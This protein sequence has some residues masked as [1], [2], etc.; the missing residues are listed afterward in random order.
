MKEVLKF[1]DVSSID[2][3]PSGFVVEECGAHYPDLEGYCIYCSQ[4]N[5]NQLKE[6]VLNNANVN[7]DHFQNTFDSKPRQAMS[8]IAM[9]GGFKSYTEELIYECGGLQQFLDRY[10]KSSVSSSPLEDADS[11]EDDFEEWGDSEQNDSEENSGEDAEQVSERDASLESAVPEQDAMIKAAAE[12]R[13][14]AERLLEDAKQRQEEV[15]KKEAET[16]S[17]MERFKDIIDRNGNL[18]AFSNPDTV[19]ETLD[20]LHTLNEKIHMDGMSQGELLSAEYVPQV[21]ELLESLS[22][23]LY[24]RFFTEYVKGITEDASDSVIIRRSAMVNDLADY[25]MRTTAGGL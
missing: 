15:Q 16:A 1:L 3:V 23:R 6:W 13:A 17:K 20:R 18:I 2:S 10:C 5:A 12:L 19:L 11:G 8:F 22:P 14:E 24:K 21:L 7:V 4:Y 9:I 25:I